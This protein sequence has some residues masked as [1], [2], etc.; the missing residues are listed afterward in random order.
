MLLCCAGLLF[1]CGGPQPKSSPGASVAIRLPAGDWGKLDPVYTS[2]SSAYQ[3]DNALYDR[4]TY[5]NSVS[6]Q[7]VP[8]L[9]T[10]WI[11]RA[12]GSL[13]LTLRTGVTCSDG[14][15]VTASVV[16]AS[17][18][19]F[20]SLSSY[21]VSY[22]GPGPYRVVADDA[23]HVTVTVGTPYSV[24]MIAFGLSEPQ[25]DIVCPAG[26]E[27]NADFSTHSYGSGPYTL[28][29]VVPGDSV[30][31]TVRRSWHWGPLGASGADPGLPSS[32]VFKKVDSETTAANLLITGGLNLAQI[33]GSDVTRLKE[34]KSLA[35]IVGNNALSDVLHYNEA[36]GH[37]TNDLKVRE[38]IS[39]AINRKS[40]SQVANSGFSVPATSII[41]TGAR[42]YASETASLLPQPST[43]NSRAILLQDGYALASNGILSKNG[44]PLT[45]H[46]IYTSSQ[47]AGV[48]YIQSQLAAVGINAIITEYPSATFIQLWRT[49]RW[50]GVIQ[51]E[52]QGS[53][54]LLA[55]AEISASPLSDPLNWGK[56]NNPTASAALQEART[57]NG[58][59]SCDAEKRFQ[60]AMLQNYDL[61][62]LA[63]TSY[64]LFGS[65]GLTWAP[66]ISGFNVAQIRWTG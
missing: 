31:T 64:Q 21:A 16:A 24:D 13:S 11:S 30:T 19:R 35:N 38:A 46:L 66:D 22:L 23:T 63:T 45:F 15:P 1:G 32:L 62:P 39:T 10:S 65:K 40:Y 58:T 5:V 57:T 41:A 61:L 36:P 49:G 12:A 37:S 18:N 42:C 44:E 28:T 20:T 17:L 50:D 52:F 6:G 51:P 54:Y 29:S 55:W 27:G 43:T 60:T 9:A 47:A 59:Q 4:L 7:I 3:I 33:A 53:T 8:Y 14:T 25:A 2:N 26:L 48:E 56:V 34:N